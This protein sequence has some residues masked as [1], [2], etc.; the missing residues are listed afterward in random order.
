MTRTRTFCLTFSI[1]KAA[2]VYVEESKTKPKWLLTLLTLGPPSVTNR[3]ITG[4][5]L[6]ATNPNPIVG[7]RLRTTNLGSGGFSS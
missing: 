2:K 1:E 3:T 7:L 5:S 6:P 4:R